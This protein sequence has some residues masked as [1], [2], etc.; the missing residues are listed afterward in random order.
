MGVDISVLFGYL[1]GVYVEAGIEL[2][3]W[4]EVTDIDVCH[5]LGLDF[6]LSAGVRLELWWKSY[7]YE[8]AETRAKLPG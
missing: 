7:S 1:V 4:V 5:R 3:L 6:V 8:F 2:G